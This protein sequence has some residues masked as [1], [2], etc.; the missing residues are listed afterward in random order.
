MSLV[1]F[2]SRSF[3]HELMGPLETSMTKMAKWVTKVTPNC[4]F[5]HRSAVGHWVALAPLIE[6]MNVELVP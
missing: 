5:V 2:A 4:I 6:S 1:V 3:L